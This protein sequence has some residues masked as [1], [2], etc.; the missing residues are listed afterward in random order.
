VNG[1]RIDVRD[2]AG[3]TG[4][5]I[6]M[7]A[8]FMAREQRHGRRFVRGGLL[9]MAAV[10][11]IAGCGDDTERADGTKST[12]SGDAPKRAGDTPPSEREREPEP[13]PKKKLVR[14][15]RQIESGKFATAAANGTVKTPELVLLSI[16]ATPPQKVQATWTLTCTNG[17]RAGTEEGLRNLESPV[18]MPLRRPVKGSE[19]CVVSANAQLTKSGQVILKLATR[20]R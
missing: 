4:A 17:K 18:S 12:D 1:R 20:S 15:D 3:A 19:S 10:V 9:T 16:K 5:D 2:K 14:I 7:D 6:S 8:G 13:E 11:A